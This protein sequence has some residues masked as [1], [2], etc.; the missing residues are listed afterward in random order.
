MHALIGMRLLC[1]LLAACAAALCVT[2]GDADC[3][4]VERAVNR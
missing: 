2:D 1:R 3:G 4:P